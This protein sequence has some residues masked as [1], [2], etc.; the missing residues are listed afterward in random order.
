MSKLFAVFMALTA[1]A[2]LSIAVG[3]ASANNDPHRV[4]Q[5]IG[6]YD[7]PAALCGFPVHVDTLVDR[8]YATITVL[9]DGSTM[10]D[11]TG[12]VFSTV[13]N[14]NTGEAITI[15]SGG[16]GTVVYNPDFT[17]GSIDLHGHTFN[18]ATNLTEFGLPSNIL[19]LTG[20]YQAT[21]DFTM[22]SVLGVATMTSITRMPHVALD[23]CAALAP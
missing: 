4:F 5:P 13:S 8:E 16:P 3:G 14:M 11:V 1:S 20:D 19:V 7:L 2:A 18:Y 9:P 23:V 22:A 21:A 6:S 10:Y 17:S 15:N 12:S